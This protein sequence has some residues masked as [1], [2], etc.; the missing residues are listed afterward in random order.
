[1]SISDDQV[2]FSRP[3]RDR[4]AR[5]RAKMEPASD[6]GTY[7]VANPH[8]VVNYTFDSRDPGPPAATPRMGQRMPR[9]QGT[10]PK[11]DNIPPRNQAFLAGQKTYAEVQA[12]EQTTK[13][14]E[15]QKAET[16]YRRGILVIGAT[17]LA[18]TVYF[19]YAV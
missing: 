17:V 4:L 6:F 13:F 12:S 5:A 18:F 2:S 10:R 16:G 1:M 8:I 15:L 14:K 9:V 7:M 11:A 3:P 19:L